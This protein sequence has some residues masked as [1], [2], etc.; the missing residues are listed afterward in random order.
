MELPNYY[1][2][3]IFNIKI[4]RKVNKILDLLWARK[5]V[6]GSWESERLDNFET[7][8]EQLANEMGFK[9]DIWEGKITKINK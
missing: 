9:F 3:I 4:M 1:T 6:Q 8:I 2:P 7:I 5:N